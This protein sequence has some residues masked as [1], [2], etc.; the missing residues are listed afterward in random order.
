MVIIMAIVHS[1]RTEFVGAH[2]DPKTKDL[3]WLMLAIAKAPASLSEWVSTAVE[4]KLAR[5]SQ[6]V[7]PVNKELQEHLSML[8]RG[9]IQ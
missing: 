4:E 5:E 1:R 3:V 8:R 9:T 2:L 6:N 7:E